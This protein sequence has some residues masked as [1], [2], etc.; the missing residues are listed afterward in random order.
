MEMLTRYLS[1]DACPVTN[2]FLDWN[3]VYT[4]EFKAGDSVADGSNQLHE[5]RGPTEE[6]PNEEISPFAKLISE[7]KKL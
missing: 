4:E 1:E 7:G 2:L 5:L 6:E 3:P